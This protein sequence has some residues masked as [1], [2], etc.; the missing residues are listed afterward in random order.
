MIH[1]KCLDSCFVWWDPDDPAQHRRRPGF[2]RWFRALQSS[3]TLAH[4]W[5]G[6]KGS[7][8]C[9]DAGRRIPRKSW[10]SIF[11]TTRSDLRQ[12]AH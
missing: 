9:V 3:V 1:K 11:S 4:S 8:K 10:S 12:N 5:A 2:F 6:S 7:L